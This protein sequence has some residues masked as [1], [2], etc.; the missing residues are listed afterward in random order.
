MDAQ[1]A[2]PGD[3][4]SLRGSGGRN[5]WPRRHRLRLGRWSVGVSVAAL[6]LLLAVA[7]QRLLSEPSPG[8]AGSAMQLVFVRWLPRVQEP[9]RARAAAS[10]QVDVARGAPARPSAGTG[11]VEPPATD[12]APLKLSLPASDRWSTSSDQRAVDAAVARVLHRRNPVPS[13]PPERFPMH[14]YS[15]A[16][17][18]R[19]VSMGLFWPPG[20]SD[21]P[22]AGVSKAIDAFSRRAT[23]ERDRRMLADAVLHRSRY[24]PP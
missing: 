9:Q 20:Y 4:A 22:C 2:T 12:V 24:C 19:M 13:S 21:D 18:V 7:L 10:G 6:H 3:V 17:I 5:G 16:D 15:P 8:G 14:N 23:N 1:W 11:R